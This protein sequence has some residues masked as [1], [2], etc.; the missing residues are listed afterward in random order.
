MK[1]KKIQ[2]ETLS[3]PNCIKKIR[4][5]LSKEPGV[6]Y[7]QVLCNSG[8][9]KVEFDGNITCIDRLIAVIESMGYKVLEPEKLAI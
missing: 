2:L 4:R 6:E 7:A 8:K 3:S 9:V 1:K 5:V